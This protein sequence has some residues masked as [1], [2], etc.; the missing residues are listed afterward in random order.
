MSMKQ[1]MTFGIKTEGADKAAKDIE[2]VGGAAQDASKETEGLNNSFSEGGNALDRMTGGAI[3]A[4][5]GIGTGIKGAV[6][7]MRTLKGAIAAT[8]IG[9]LLV[10]VASLV[11]Y[12]TRTKRGAEVLQVATASVGVIFDKLA[13]TLALVGEF[14]VGVFTN[15]KEALMNF[16]DLLKKNIINRFEGLLE[17]VPAIGKAIGLLFR[18]QFKKAGKV[19][20]DAVGKVA[21]GVENVTDKAADLAKKGGAAFSNFTQEVLNAVSATA[22]LERRAIALRDAQ[23][24]TNVEFAKQRQR[25]AELQLASEDLNKPVEERIAALEEASAIEQELADRRLR[26]AEE[27]VAIQEQQMAIT[28]STADDYDELANK[29]IALFEAQRNS[30]NVQRRLTTRVN[31]LYKEQEAGIQAIID[32][33]RKRVKEIEANA[34]KAREFTLSSQQKELEDLENSYIDK[35]EAQLDYIDEIKANEFAYQE[36]ELQRQ[37]EV[38]KQ[39]EETYLAKKAEIVKKYADAEAKAVDDSNKKQEESTRNTQL[40]RIGA[41]QTAFSALIALNE[42]YASDDE[43]ANKRVFQRNKNLSKGQ[44]IVNTYAAIADALAKDATFPGSR[45]IAAASAATLGF[46]QVRKINQTQYQSPT[47]TDDVIDNPLNDD[48]GNLG[49]VTAPTLDLGFLGEGAVGS[50]QAFVISENVTNQQQADQLV[51]DQTVL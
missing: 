19:A 6:A 13:D 34:A 45:F 47:S 31:A 5:K 18:G 9:L 21:L 50:I 43:E 37:Q 36:G 16:V 15:P 41:V 29:Q 20:A 11:S 42:S 28:E 8:G 48:T 23:R 27:A 49:N 14:L 7:G 1:W 51:A 38:L 39:I 25:I 33:E 46:A 17:L 26:E 2:K 24:A 4:F 32:A 22:A 10:A 3:T 30:L 35:E 44:A 40:A 12:F